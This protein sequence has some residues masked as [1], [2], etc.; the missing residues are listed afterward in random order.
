MNPLDAGAAARAL[1]SVRRAFPEV[2]FPA[3]MVISRGGRWFDESG[4]AHAYQDAEAEEV[5]RFFGGRPWMGI[6]PAELLRWDHASVSPV[7]LAPAAHAYYLPCYLVTF[8]TMPLDGYAVAVLEQAI[9]MWT[10]P[11]ARPSSPL[12]S[13]PGSAA[14]RDALNA[15]DEADFRAFVAALDPPQRRAL[16][17]FLEVFEPVLEDED[18]PSENPARRALGAF[19]RAQRT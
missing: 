5:A 2:P 6:A 10:P 15:A 3:R 9:T 18:S 7:F 14:Q 4:A 19:W 1:S 8:L 16:A 11:A 12:A 17:T 13:Q